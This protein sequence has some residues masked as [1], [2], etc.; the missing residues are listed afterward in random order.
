MTER[1]FRDPSPSRNEP[2]VFHDEDAPPVPAVPHRYMSP[3]PLPVKSIRRPASVEP[4]ERVLS[5]PPRP[6]GRGSALIEDQGSCQVLQ[7]ESLP[8]PRATWELYV[9][10]LKVRPET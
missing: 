9:K 5:P 4:P 3:P 10:R 8:N 7:E 6:N 2:T 1:S